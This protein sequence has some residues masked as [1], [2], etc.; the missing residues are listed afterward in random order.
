MNR[1]KPPDDR[2]C[3][4]LSQLKSQVVGLIFYPLAL[5]ILLSIALVT[6]CLGQD[7][8]Q[9]FQDVKGRFQDPLTYTGHLG[10]QLSA[11]QSNLMVDR[12]PPFAGSLNAGLQIGILGVQ[13]PL[14]FIYS[15]GGTAFNV[16]L[17][18]FGFAGISPSYHGYTLHLG[19]RSLEFGKYSF[20][21]HSFRGV[22][23]EIDKEKWYARGFF[24][25]LQRAQINDYRGFQHVNPLLRRMGWGALLGYIPTSKSAIEFSLFKGWDDAQ[26]IP[27]NLIDSTFDIYASENVILSTAIK[28]SLAEKVDLEIKYSTSGFTERQDLIPD[29]RTNAFRTFLGI[30]ETNKSTRWNH[31]LEAVME[32]QTGIGQLSFSYEKIDPGYRTLGALF[33]QDDQENITAG[34]ATQWFDHKLSLLANGGIQRNNLGK[35]KSDQYRRLIGSIFANYQASEKIILNLGLSNFSAVNRQ[36]RI[37]DP[38]NPNVLTELALTNFNLNGGIQFRI[39]TAH[40]I[41]VNFLYQ[42][43]QTITTT[44]DILEEVN[45]IKNVT[46]LYNNLWKSTGINSSVQIFYNRFTMA[47]FD[48]GQ[49]GIAYS[50]SRSLKNKKFR[51]TLSL[52]FSRNQQDN[53][54]TQQRSTGYLFQTRMGCS[55]KVMASQQLQADAVLFSNTGTTINSFFESRFNLR[56]AINLQSRSK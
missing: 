17:P 37:L 32:A 56:Y 27:Q 43:N 35:D 41:A 6:E 9:T 16:T 7:I 33:F 42:K 1:P 14:N 31:A 47:Q 20:S 30:L 21:N 22:G 49:Q 39:A 8:E 53:F 2:Y 25:R 24:G 10:F 50:A 19:D 55:W 4:D 11:Y 44:D 12:A 13:T 36:L 51:P 54:L 15:S 45:S 28:Q 38:E 46:V 29:H 3:C 40:Q 48:Q 18:S 52:S 23:A 34:I 26:S 5:Q